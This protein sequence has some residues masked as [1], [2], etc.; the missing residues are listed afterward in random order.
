[1]NTVEEKKADHAVEIFNSVYQTNMSS[2]K[3]YH[4]HFK[5]P[6]RRRL[7]GGLCQ[8]C[9]TAHESKAG[10]CWTGYHVFVQ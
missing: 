9:R 3:M 4:K 7:W 6:Q 5:N 2:E 1:M 10:L 8:L